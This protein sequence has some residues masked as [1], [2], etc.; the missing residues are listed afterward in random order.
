[1][2]PIN[3]RLIGFS[4]QIMSAKFI[5]LAFSYKHQAPFLKLFQN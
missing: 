2:Q 1:M 3:Q 5:N 4:A